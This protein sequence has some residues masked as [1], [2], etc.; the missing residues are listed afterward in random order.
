MRG[1]GTR[2]ARRRPR[3]RSPGPRRRSGRRSRAARRR[4]RATSAAVPRTLPSRP[5]SRPPRPARR[6]ARRAAC[7]LASGAA[8]SMKTSR[9]SACSMPETG[10][11]AP[12][13]T[14]VAV[15]AMVPVTQMPPNS[16][17]AMLATP[18]ATSSQLERCRRPVMPSATTADS[19][20][21]MAPSSAKA[22]ASGSTA[23]SLLQAE[24][25][26]RPASGRLRGMPPKR[27]PIVADRQMQQA[28]TA[29]DASADRDQ[30]AR[31][32]AAASGAPREWRRSTAADADAR[33]G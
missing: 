14:L 27:L 31:P 28:D 2:R 16:A 10:P 1:P 19:S 13:R 23:A 22:T 6:P 33:P 7:R 3:C 12:A 21:S 26:A 17:E 4:R 20:D 24:R 18:C 25:P 29:S 15:R 30:H 11:C 8:T 32:S 5:C 9:N